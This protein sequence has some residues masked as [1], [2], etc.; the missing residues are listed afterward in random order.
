M[1]NDAFVSGAADHVDINIDTSSG[2]YDRTKYGINY[3]YLF[4]SATKVVPNKIPTI[5]LV[6]LRHA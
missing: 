3:P 1:V 6:E 5:Q 2:L 4:G